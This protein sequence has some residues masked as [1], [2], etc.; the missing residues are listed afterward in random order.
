MAFKDIL[1]ADMAVFINS[2]EFGETVTYTPS[3][4]TGASIS[5]VVIREEYTKDY[6]G[7]ELHL[8]KRARATIS[9][10]DIST[11]DPDGDEMTFD[12]ATWTVESFNPV[13]QNTAYRI[14]V[15]SH[16]I[17]SRDA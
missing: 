6:I 7:S 8:M 4:G 9:A 2:D 10:A 13:G 17:L 15:T 1:A 5:A 12:G 3:G 14:T 11:P 16:E